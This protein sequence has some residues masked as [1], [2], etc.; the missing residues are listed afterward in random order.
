MIVTAYPTMIMY[1]SSPAGSQAADGAD[2]CRRVDAG[3]THR[4]NRALPD[5]SADVF[6]IGDLVSFA[7]LVAVAVWQ[8]HRPAVHKRLMV[9][10]T[11]GGLMPAALTHLIGHSPA[12]R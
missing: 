4:P 6:Q 12:L 5:S 8:R 2:H 9:L 7:L 10:A 1:S 11:V 3:G